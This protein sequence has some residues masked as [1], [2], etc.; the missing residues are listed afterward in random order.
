MACWMHFC[1]NSCSA[2]DPMRWEEPSRSLKCFGTTVLTVLITL[3]VAFWVS[4]I[5]ERVVVYGYEIPLV[6][7]E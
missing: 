4:F 7:D 6:K 3:E 2:S 5:D 1:W